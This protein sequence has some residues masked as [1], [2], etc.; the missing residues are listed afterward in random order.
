MASPSSLTERKSGYFHSLSKAITNET[1]YP[2]ES[3]FKSSHTIKY[4]EVLAESIPYCPDVASADAFA[5]NSSIIKK[6]E[7]KELTE[8]PGSN[9]QAWYIN[10][11]KFVRP[12]ISP[13]DVVEDGT[14][15]PSI[16]FEAKLF[17]ENGSFI[18]STSGVWFIDYYAGI[19][20]F[21]SSYTPNDLGYGIPKISLYVY[22]G[23][24]VADLIN[25]VIN[26]QS[27]LSILTTEKL[28]ISNNKIALNY[29]CKGDVIYNKA[30]IYDNLN[31]EY[32][33][34]YSCNSSSNGLFI[35]FNST[36]NLNGKYA[37]VSYLAGEII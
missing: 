7:L 36:D 9:G 16:G 32:F 14:N 29:K 22:I 6:Y 8:I 25:S 17:K 11:N 2:F 18:S 30:L 33:T 27:S 12:F 5:L 21:E 26:T 31:S 19:V 15:M 28:L 20:H 34:E 3:K 24:T 13:V 23:K 35:E 4:D 37:V 10:D 1:Q